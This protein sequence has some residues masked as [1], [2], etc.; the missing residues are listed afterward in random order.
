MVFQFKPNS[1]IQADP[2]TAGAMCEALAKDGGLTAKRLLDANRDPAAPLHGEFEWDDAVA[3]ESFREQQ[4]GHIIRSLVVVREAVET[5][6]PVRAF[7]NV[8]NGERKYEPIVVSSPD[9]TAQMMTAARRDMAAFIQKYRVL[10]ELTPIFTA[11]DAVLGQEK[12]C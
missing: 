9:L 5:A 11:M 6:P 4:A 7:V 12:E 2:Q 8:Q 1:R 10:S 3:A